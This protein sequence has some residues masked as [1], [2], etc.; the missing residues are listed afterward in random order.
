MRKAQR[1][2][3]GA[4]PPEALFISLVTTKAGADQGGAGYAALLAIQPLALQLLQV[5]G[6]HLQE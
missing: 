3:I 6:L 4:E 2:Q 1:V 5:C